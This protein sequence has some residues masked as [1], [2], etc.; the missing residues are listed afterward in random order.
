MDILE[1]LASELAGA[2]TEGTAG[3][4]VPKRTG[5]LDR[6][7]K[8]SV[9]SLKVSCILGEALADQQSSTYPEVWADYVGLRVQTGNSI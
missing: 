6:L 5:G 4:C 1:E 9:T 7:S 8:F 2:T 3:F